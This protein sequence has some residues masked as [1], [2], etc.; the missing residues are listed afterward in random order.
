MP[1][2]VSYTTENGRLKKQKKHRPTG[3]HGHEKAMAAKG[4]LPEGSHFEATYGDGHWNGFLSI[5]GSHRAMLTA[6]PTIAGIRF[7]G[8]A[9]GLFRLLSMLDD[10]YRAWV[11]AQPSRSADTG[12]APD[13]TP[14]SSDAPDAGNAG[15]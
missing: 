14:S 8:T 7:E 10:Q 2:K 1:M 13:A 12:P 3:V 6:I 5:P 15:K 4:R 11:A 9:S